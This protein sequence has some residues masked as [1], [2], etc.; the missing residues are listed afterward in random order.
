VEVACPGRRTAGQQGMVAG[1]SGR[2]SKH[3]YHLR[4]GMREGVSRI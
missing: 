2:R 3:S 4:A 1:E